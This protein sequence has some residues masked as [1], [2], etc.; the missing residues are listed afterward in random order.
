MAYNR[1]DTKYFAGQTWD[2]DA[3]AQIDDSFESLWNYVTPQMYGAV[4]DGVTDD[5][6]AVQAALDSGKNVYFP[7]GRYKVTETLNAFQPCK[8]SMSKPYP[9]IWKSG[10]TGDMPQTPEQYTMGSR[11]E[12]Y[13]TGDDSI[14][15]L[16][17]DSVQIDGLYV[18]GMPGFS[19]TIFKFDGNYGTRT[20]PS[21]VRLKHIKVDTYGIE[22]VPQCMFDFHPVQA[23]FV[24]VDD[25]QIGGARNRQNCHYGFKM[26]LEGWTN[27]TFLS[28]ICI[29]T[30]TE[31]SFFM[32]GEQGCANFAID[33]LIIQ[34]FPKASY[35]KVTH[36]DIFTIKDMGFVTLTNC[37][38]WDLHAATYEQV[39]NLENAQIRCN[40]GCH[41]EFQFHDKTLVNSINE[42]LDIAEAQGRL[43]GKGLVSVEQTTVGAVNEDNNLR[44]TLADGSE[45]DCPFKIGAATL[46]EV[47][48]GF[49][50]CNSTSVETDLQPEYTWSGI[51]EN[52]LFKSTSALNTTKSYPVIPGATTISMQDVL[53]NTAYCHCAFFD[54]EGNLVSRVMGEAVSVR[55]TKIIDIPD[56]AATF[57]L[58]IQSG[59]TIGKFVVAYTTLGKPQAISS[60]FNGDVYG[61][62][63]G[64]YQA[65]TGGLI[66]S[67][68]YTSSELIPVEGDY[69]AI[70]ANARAP[71]NGT[72]VCYYDANKVF[73]GSLIND[74][75]ALG[76]YFTT[77]LLP[78]TT[79]YIG[80]TWM[81]NYTDGRIGIT[82][83]KLNSMAKGQVVRLQSPDGNTWQLQIT[84][85]GTLSAIKV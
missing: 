77:A 3:I 65:A 52:G 71:A 22:V 61:K 49:T 15:F 33:N 46:E 67:T 34:T 76:T 59:D 47:S 42:Q 48:T 26:Q 18:R 39:I 63:A 4:A 20:Y 30:C 45:I 41:E 69:I 50:Y 51:D 31:Y 27:S 19:G 57:N 37:W 83:I 54:A 25:I 60:V 66:G 78:K 2:E 6:A 84:D 40:S 73:L 7:E 44:F 14:G 16:C 72:N 11:I 64:Y 10:G 82:A 38:I 32:Q 70:C 21:Q 55:K 79:K 80:L 68:G 81:N 56:G 62:H 29:D 58:T 23:Y 85:D 75:G 9:C 43:S 12:S 5:T 28:N 17:G 74:N 24:L 1:L 36:K 35:D 53:N 13:V 8:I